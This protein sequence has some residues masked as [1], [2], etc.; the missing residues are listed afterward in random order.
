MWSSPESGSRI[1]AALLLTGLAVTGLLVNERVVKPMV[2]E[3]VG[4]E[5]RPGIQTAVAVEVNS[6]VGDVP[7]GEVVV[8]EAEIN[9]RIEEAGD[10][11][12]LDAATVDLTPEGVRVNLTAWGVSGDYQADLQVNQGSLALEGGSLGGPLALIVP[13]GELE[14]AANEAIAS[15]LNDLGYQVESVALDEG[16]IT[17]GL[18]R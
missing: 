7:A 15:A 11:G 5:L 8:T 14:Q 17:L 13:A 9:Q 4:D 6:Q 10:L 2:A 12:P 3:Q 18:A 16:T 1:V